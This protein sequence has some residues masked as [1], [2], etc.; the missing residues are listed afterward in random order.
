MNR[1]AVRFSIPFLANLF[2][3]E[4]S[5][6]S[7]MRLWSLHPQ[8]LDAKG[9]VA[10]WREALL[11]KAVLAGKT[12]GYRQHPQLTRFRAHNQPLAAIS[13][14]LKV[15]YEEACRRGYNFNEGKV[16]RVGQCKSISVTSGQVQFELNHLKR[17]LWMRDRR[18]YHT[19]KNI[20]FP[21][22]HPL[23]HINEGEI[24]EWERM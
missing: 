10:C 6:E 15:L 17:K 2:E 9:L 1:S 3:I 13:A 16:G 20:Q 18:K 24:E 23:F 14:Y 22:V 4:Y 5:C 8:Y 19:L 12:R 7:R 11:A 21:S